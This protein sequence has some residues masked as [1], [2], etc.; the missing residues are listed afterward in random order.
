MKHKPALFAL[1]RLHAD[2]G[3][4]IKANRKEAVRLATDMKHVE[5]VIR[6]IEP[7]YDVRRIS[8]RR[9]NLANPY[10]KRG[11]VFR[12]VLAILRDATAP[13]TTRQ[14]VEALFRQQGTDSP[15][16]DAIRAMVGAVHSS[17]RNHE[18]KTVEASGEGMPVK[19]LLIG[20]GKK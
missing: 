13:L 3:G 18:G 10:F 15:T 7:G 20:T 4:K 9:K 17:L 2:L 5:A 12:G 16:M 6:M 19:W 8:A 14:I 1:L 11:T